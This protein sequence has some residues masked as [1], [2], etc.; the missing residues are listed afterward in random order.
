MKTHDSLKIEIFY[1]SNRY[2]LLISIFH[3]VE[4]FLYYTLLSNR[5]Y[6]GGSPVRKICN[7]NVLGPENSCEA[8]KVGNGNFI[9]VGGTSLKLN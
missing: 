2:K 4:T 5:Q 8:R 3:H 1:S 6:W 9:L 7:S